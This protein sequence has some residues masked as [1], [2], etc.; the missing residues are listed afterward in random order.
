MLSGISFCFGFFVW[1]LLFVCLFV[2]S[3]DIMHYL[4]LNIL[5]ERKNDSFHLI[6]MFLNTLFLLV[7]IFIGCLAL[8]LM[9][10]SFVNEMNV[11]S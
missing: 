1:F 10:I 8:F 4:N 5:S 2:M 6:R 9:E 11:H 3:V 7:G